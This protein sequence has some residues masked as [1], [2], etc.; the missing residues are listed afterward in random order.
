LVT[1]VSPLWSEV[2][3]GAPWTLSVAVS[4]TPLA[5]QWFNQNGP[6]SGATTNS[7]TFNAVAGTNYYQVVVTNAAGS[8]TSSIAQVISSTNIVTVKN[9]SFE[10]GIS[11]TPSSWTAFN[12]SWSSVVDENGGNYSDFDPLDP[13]A[14][15]NYF[16]ACNT[17]PGQATSGIYQV[18]G[19]LQPNTTYT[20]TVA[21]GYSDANPVTGQ[22]TWSPGTISLIN[23]N[24]NTGIVLATTN[25][26][27]EN[28]DT[29]QDFSATFISGPSVSGNLTVEL[30]VPG[31]P[32]YQAQFDNVRLTKAPA[33]PV[34]PPTLLTDL[35]PLDWVVTT[36]TPMTLAV[37]ANGNP[38]HYQWFNQNG[39]ISGATTNSYSFNALAGTNSYY[40]S[41]TNSAGSVTSSIAQ[42]VSFTNI[43]TVKNFSFE[44]GVVAGPGGGTLPLKWTPFNNNNWCAVSSGAFATIPDGTYFF[45]L[46]EGPNDPTGGIYQD[47]GALLPNTTYTLT[48]AIGNSPGTPVSGQS[49]W[50]PGI[51]SL[52]NGT[53]NTGVPLASTNGLPDTAGDWQ[54]YSVTFTT[55]SSVSGDLT[56]ALSVAGAPTYQATF[57]DVRLT[58]AAAPAIVPPALLVDLNP[59]DSEVTTGTP[60]TLS[61]V[62]NGNPLVYQWFNQNGPISGATKTSYSFNAV[63]G[64]NSYYVRVTNSAGAIFSSTGAVISAANIV[65]VNNFS[66]ENGTTAGPG[67]G[68]LPVA[69]TQAGSINWCTVTVGSSY[70]SMPDGTNLFAIN[71]GPNDSTGGI[72]QDVGPLLANTTYTL[73]VA[74]AHA[75][76]QNSP[77]II[78]LLN[79]TGNTGI[80]L[81]STNGIPDAESTWQ[82]YTTTFT[83]GASVSGDLAVELSVAPSGTWQALFDDVRL[84]KVSVAPPTP[85]KFAKSIISGGNLI[86]TGT[87]GTAYS[88][89]TWLSTTNLA[90][91]IIWTTNSTGTLDANGGF[92]NAIPVS[93]SQPPSFFRLRIP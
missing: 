77:G 25:G 78:S 8:V 24:D 4:G 17:G 11:T 19:A 51:I 30:A 73:T 52:F 90:A 86:V 12:Y 48:V 46:N 9:F 62:A 68:L 66:F 32:T 89:Y 59:L 28:A 50:S 81:A 61:I 72:Y 1:D 18:C 69:W 92:S 88:G 65:T 13:P 60:M 20:L 76:W 58:K 10:D 2:T 33:P 6:I 91:P 42:V 87:G 45:A 38:L 16:F 53:D 82:D 43:V 83:S 93:A 44:D 85:P 15:G 36:G 23:G 80:L 34:I 7:Y 31:L 41:V 75:N 47:V 84:T 67:G 55:G 79:G 37:L 5:Y 70:A 40:V 56:V 35:S 21:I 29:W 26:L 64:T 63:A 39:P 3:T 27:P 22:S 14:Q 54:D 49:T 71:E 74:I 57:D